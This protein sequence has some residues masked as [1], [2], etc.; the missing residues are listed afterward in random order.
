MAVLAD[1]KRNLAAVAARVREDGGKQVRQIDLGVDLLHD[2][3]VALHSYVQ[4]ISGERSLFRHRLLWRLRLLP[5]LRRLRPFPRLRLFRRLRLL[6]LLWLLGSRRC[7]RARWCGRRRWRG[8]RRSL[9]L[10]RGDGGGAFGCGLLPRGFG[11]LLNLGGAELQALDDAEETLVHFAADTLA[12]LG[13][14]LLEC[15]AWRHFAEQLA[16]NRRQVDLQMRRID[17]RAGRG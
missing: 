1:G 2:L 4:L 12:L 5:P 6:A 15:A 7:R 11:F 13:R 3:A 9:R 16:A 17:V 8:G 10:R 14:H